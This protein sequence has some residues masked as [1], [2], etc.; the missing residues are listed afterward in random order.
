MKIMTKIFIIFFISSFS[1]NAFA[2]LDPGTGSLIIQGIIA[3]LAMIGVVVKTF[4]YKIS[5]LFGKKR[6][7]SVLDNDKISADKNYK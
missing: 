3:G 2:Y 6:P 4:W 1:V 5:S 7:K